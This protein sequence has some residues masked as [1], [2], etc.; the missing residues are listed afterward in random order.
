VCVSCFG[1]VVTTCQ[2]LSRKTPLRTPVCGK[3]IISTGPSLKRMFVL[4]LFHFHYYVFSPSLHNIFHMLMARCSLFVL[5]VPFN[6]SQPTD[7]RSFWFGI[8]P[9]ICCVFLFCGKDCSLTWTRHVI[10]SAFVVTDG[11][12]ITLW[13]RYNEATFHNCLF[14]LLSG[15]RRTSG[16]AP[17]MSSA[18]S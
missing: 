10:N 4:I 14:K 7:H 11:Y 1:L 3:E 2:W 18:V 12:A 8:G 5:K 17:N 9:V 16:Y 15:K 13:V 6:T